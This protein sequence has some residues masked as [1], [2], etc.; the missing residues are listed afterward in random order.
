MAP[1]KS[2]SILGDT[3]LPETL[4]IVLSLVSF[5]MILV[6]LKVYDNRPIFV[7]HGATLNT[8]VSTIATLG[9]AMLLF[10]VSA[11]MSQWKYIWFSQ[12][13]RKLI[14]FE[15]FDSAS[16]GPSG[17]LSLLWSVNFR[18][19][20]SIGAGIT[21]LSLAIDPFVQQIVGVGERQVDATN[22]TTIA[23]A[24][25]Y[26]RGT[27]LPAPEVSLSGPDGRPFDPITINT[28]FSMQSAIL[29][30]LSNLPSA[31]SQQMTVHCPG[32][33]CIWPPYLSLG[34]CSTCVDVTN[35][36]TK[37]TI[38][39]TAETQS[40]QYNSLL[41]T[42]PGNGGAAPDLAAAEF[43]TYNLSNGL[44]MDDNGPSGPNVP[45]V[46]YSTTNRSNTTAFK[47]NELLL[48]SLTVIKYL[49]EGGPIPGVPMIAIECSL[50]YC[51]NNYTSEMS[52]GTLSET[53]KPLPSIVIPPSWEQQEESWGPLGT[54]GSL[55]TS[56]V[57]ILPNASTATLP[58]LQLGN[59]FN[60]S[61]A[62]INS[63]ASGLTSVLT[64]TLQYGCTGF[65]LSNA[66]FTPQSTQLIYESPD[67]NSTFTG[68]AMSM[69]NIIR[70]NDDNGTL[71]EGTVG[72]TVYNAHLKWLSLPMIAVFGGFLLLGLTVFYTR[73]RHLSIWKSSALSVLKVG[74]T[75]TNHLDS[76]TMVGG[77]EKKAEKT[78]IVLFD[79]VSDNV[80]DEDSTQGLGSSERL[81]M[82]IPRKAL[83]V[84]SGEGP[85]PSIP[86]L[87]FDGLDLSPRR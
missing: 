83:S 75:T 67:L 62:A 79:A 31:I 10:T 26:S 22:S 2:R 8:F 55:E 81:K 87:S 33:H 57:E 36:L 37:Y 24:L 59:Q 41:F 51:V 70:L 9:K 25:R 5:L 71:V 14:D 3:W 61:Q 39:N 78:Y 84:S 54:L 23:R 19:L 86:P 20:V 47:D 11:C 21:I 18:S 60:I 50:A 27:F 16:R 30:G 45:L 63:I 46:S 82:M 73:M 29:F 15:V 7:W 74:A 80:Q 76:E 53:A 66:E 40:T 35:L 13:R 77:M 43:F 48:Y 64:G 38:N 68:L 69:N 72:I 49:T 52:N 85:S 56:Y 32:A 6:L 58:D 12:A 17:S 34:I 44:Y 1:R 28:D 65:Y 42:L 4:A